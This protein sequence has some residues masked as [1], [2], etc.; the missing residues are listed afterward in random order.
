MADVLA[1]ARSIRCT[2]RASPMAARCASA[3]AARRWSTRSARCAGRRDAAA[4]D[5]FC[6]WLRRALRASRCPT[7]STATSTRRSTSSA[8]WP[9]RCAGAPRGLPAPRHR[10]GAA[11]RRR[12]PA[13]PLQLPVDVRRAGP[14]R[15]ARRV[16]R[17]H[18]HGHRRGV[19]VADGGMHA[20]PRAL[21]A[22]ASNAGVTFRYGTRVERILSRD[23]RRPGHR[24][25]A[26]RWRA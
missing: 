16:R 11:L 18:L 19:V 4:F 2:E 1:L 14:V 23:G 22:A 20:V 21:A 15:G 13:P 10:S 9:R 5:P 25:R 8:R 26:R 7:S 17:D 3:T 24:G 12:A 6:D